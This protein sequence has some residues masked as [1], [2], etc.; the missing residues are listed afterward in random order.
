MLER[1]GAALNFAGFWLFVLSALAMIALWVRALFAWWA[2]PGVAAGVVTCPLA[3]FFPFVEWVV[4]GR[5]PVGTF[6]IWLGGL[7]AL[8]VSFAGAHMAPIPT[9]EGARRE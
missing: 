5:F 9:R 3:A 8:G 4:E 6:A 2:W 7:V 1:I